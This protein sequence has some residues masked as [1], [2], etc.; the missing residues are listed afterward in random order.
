MSQKK[1]P[2]TTRKSKNTKPQEDLINDDQQLQHKLAALTDLHKGLAILK[3]RMYQSKQDLLAY[4]DQYPH[5]KNEKYTIDDRMIRYQDKKN[6]GGLTQKVVMKGLT[7]YL[8]SKGAS[9][10]ELEVSQIM[11]YLLSQRSMKIVPTI[12]I[13][14]KKIDIEQSDDN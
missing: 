5:L 11:S 13:R 7:E 12:D 1:N 6:T 4:F 9:H 10:P 14:S 2:N 8:Q 3:K